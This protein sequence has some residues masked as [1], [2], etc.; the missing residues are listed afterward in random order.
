MK[1]KYFA[2][3]RDARDAARYVRLREWQ[4]REHYCTYNEWERESEREREW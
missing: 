1:S 3:L 4:I 2:Y